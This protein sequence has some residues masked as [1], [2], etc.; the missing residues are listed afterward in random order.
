MQ[1]AKLFW[2][3]FLCT[4]TLLT[5][6]SKGASSTCT[7]NE[8][9]TQTKLTIEAP[10]E[11]QE[12]SSISFTQVIPKDELLVSDTDLQEAIDD[13]VSLF[14]ESFGLKSSDISYDIGSNSVT[15]TLK[16]NANQML[17]ISVPVYFDDLVDGLEDDGYYCD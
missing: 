8:G 9:T 3:S 11:D 5:G 6:C 2:I 12:I 17:G 15:F 10:G 16:L 1:K 7:L 4:G 13:Q 14:Q